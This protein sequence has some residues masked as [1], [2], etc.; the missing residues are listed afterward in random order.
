MLNNFPRTWWSNFCINRNLP[1]I[2]MLLISLLLT[3]FW[4]YLYGPQN[5]Y[6]IY[7]YMFSPSGSCS[8]LGD[9]WFSLFFTVIFLVWYNLIHAFIY[10]PLWL[11]LKKRLPINPIKKT[12]SLWA[13]L[14]TL[15]LAV[16]CLNLYTDLSCNPMYWNIVV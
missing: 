15:Y 11:Y 14:L 4:Q 13:V 10:I 8:L 7:M 6:P 1:T 3:Y 12:L 16:S 2:T 9:I 5:V